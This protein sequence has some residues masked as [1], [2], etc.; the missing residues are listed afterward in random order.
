MANQVDCCCCCC[1]C[2]MLFDAECRRIIWWLQFFFLLV[3]MV[4][5]VLL[6]IIHIPTWEDDDLYYL[7]C[8][9]CVCV[10]TFTDVVVVFYCNGSQPRLLLLLLLM[11]Y[12]HHRRSEIGPRR[13][14]FPFLFHQCTDGGDQLGC[15]KI[16]VLFTTLL[17]THTHTDTLGY[18]RKIDWKCVWTS[19][20]RTVCQ[21]EKTTVT[22]IAFANENV[23]WNCEEN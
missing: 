9:C 7:V 16:M 19:G 6:V 20:N 3:V 15:K 17:Q 14:A 8:C 5:V 23:N 10:A 22:A 12:D 18:Q 13:L 1:C 2:W 11:F 4:V 21:W